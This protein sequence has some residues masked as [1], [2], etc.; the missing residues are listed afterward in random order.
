MGC[1]YAP[2]IFIPRQ[3]VD[4]IL[5]TNVLNVLVLS[6]GRVVRAFCLIAR[7]QTISL[8]MQT[9]INC[10]VQCEVDTMP[11]LWILGAVL[12]ICETGNESHF[13]ISLSKGLQSKNVI[14]TYLYSRIHSALLFLHFVLISV[15]FRSLW[16]CYF[17]M[18]SEM[19]ESERSKEA[20]YSGIWC[21]AFLSP[22]PRGLVSRWAKPLLTIHVYTGLVAGIMCRMKRLLC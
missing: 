14:G 20:V 4:I 3:R 16:N 13:C 1:C 6:D 11:V 15:S 8:Y 5:W 22:Y 18:Q 7:S 17:L 19:L 10:T 12:P 2:S 9:V 21:S